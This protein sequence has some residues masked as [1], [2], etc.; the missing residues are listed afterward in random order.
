SQDGAGGAAP[1]RFELLA[2]RVGA[3]GRVDGPPALGSVAPGTVV[4][5]A[6]PALLA[7]GLIAPTLV[8]PQDP[9]RETALGGTLVDRGQG[10]TQAAARRQVGRIPGGHQVART[11]EPGREISHPALGGVAGAVAVGAVGQPE[12]ADVIAEGV[13]PLRE[14]RGEATCPPAAGA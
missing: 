9:Q 1:G 13:V 11:G 8:D 10:R 6:G 7:V 3:R 12:G 4:A 14:G 5:G 2:L